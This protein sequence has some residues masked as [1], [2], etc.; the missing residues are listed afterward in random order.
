MGRSFFSVASSRACRLRVRSSASSGLRQTTQSLAWII[1]RSHLG[2]IA[3][4]EQRKLNGSCLNQAADRRRAQGRDPV[5]ARWLD[6]LVQT[7]LGNH[8]P[9]ADQ[10]H[11]LKCETP[12]NL[13]DLARE[14]GRIADIALKDL[15]CHRAPLGGAQ[16]PKHDLQLAFA[17]PIVAELGQWAGAALKVGGRDVVEHQ[18]AVL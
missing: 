3:L 10:H 18:R 15:Y 8:A 12:F 7:R 11:T 14:R 17:V 16:K 9:I 4:V 13:A 1:G 5:K 2:E 6:G